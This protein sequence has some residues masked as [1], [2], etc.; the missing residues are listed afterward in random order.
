MSDLLRE[1]EEDLKQEKVQRALKTFAPIVLGGVV[2]LIAGLIGR[3]VYTGWQESES[4]AS[5]EAWFTAS[6]RYEVGHT[7]DG[8][9]TMAELAK[10][11]Y[12]GTATLAALTAAHWMKGEDKAGAEKLLAEV[13]EDADRDA[14]LR[15]LARLRLSELDQDTKRLEGEAKPGEPLAPV[16][17]LQLAM[18]QLTKKQDKEAVEG[19]KKL[20][21]DAAASDEMRL[22]AKQLLAALGHPQRKDVKQDVNPPKVSGADAKP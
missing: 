16:A 19:L 6:Q 17:Q 20:S 13:S 5:A 3:Q 15:A 11:G 9:K 21:E 4:E 12:S 10:D 1:I 8:A 7:E 18:L 22:Q 14:G 2:L